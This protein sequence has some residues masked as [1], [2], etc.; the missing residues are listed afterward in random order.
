MIRINLNEY[1]WIHPNTPEAWEKIRTLTVQAATRRGMVRLQF[2][3][4]MQMFGPD[5]VFGYNPPFSMD[6]YFEGD[7]QPVEDV[8]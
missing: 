4:V 1:V 2:W 8:P 5:I 3:E 6:V 7:Y